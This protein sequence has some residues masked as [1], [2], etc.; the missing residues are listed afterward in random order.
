MCPRPQNLCHT[1]L[2]LSNTGQ[3]SIRD[4]LVRETVCLSAEVALGWGTA[5]RVPDGVE[6]PHSSKAAMCKA[7]PRGR[8]IG[9]L[10]NAQIF[11]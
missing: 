8:A 9:F 3:A 2:V 6:P 10:P 5:W 4:W 7:S 11:A 1:S